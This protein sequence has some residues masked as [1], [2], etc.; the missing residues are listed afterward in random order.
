MSAIKH[1][2]VSI[3]TQLPYE[4]WLWVRIISTQNDS[5]LTYMITLY[6]YV[7]NYTYQTK[8]FLVDKM[9]SYIVLKLVAYHVSNRGCHKT[10]HDLSRLNLGR[11]KKTRSLINTR[12]PNL[13][14][15][16]MVFMMCSISG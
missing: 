4:I 5:I 13:M 3:P 15:F 6:I 8:C 10:K 16:P 11:E 1:H 2:Q 12:R 14:V 9:F 7:C